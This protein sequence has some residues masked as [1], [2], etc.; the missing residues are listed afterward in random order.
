MRTIHLFAR[1]SDEQIDKEQMAE[2]GID[3][4]RLAK[5]IA[6]YIERDEPMKYARF[7]IFSMVLQLLEKAIYPQL[8]PSI[9]S[10]LEGEPLVKE[11]S[12]MI[13]A[14]CVSVK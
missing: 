2:R 12:S 1:L 14:Y 8:T 5:L 11:V 10:E 4:E 7:A 3:Y 6:P 13:F 9:A